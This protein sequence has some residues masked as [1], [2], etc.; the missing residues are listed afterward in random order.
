MAAAD[1]AEIYRLAVMAQGAAGQVVT[2]EDPLDR[3]EVELGGQ[4]HHCEIF[5]V[6]GPVAGGGIAVAAHEMVEHRV[7][8]IGV[9]LQVH[10]HEAGK[11]Q[12]ARIDG[13]AHAG[14]ARRHGVDAVPLEPRETLFLGQCVDGGGRAAGI[15][16]PAHQ[17]GRTGHERMILRL[18]PGDGGQHRHG[19]LAHGRD[20]EIR[21]ELR[22]Q[23]DAGID[24]VIE[25]KPAGA[26]RH[27][28][29]IDPVGD[30][31]L[32]AVE[33]DLDSAAQQRGVVARHRRDDQKLRL[34]LQLRGRLAEGDD[35]AERAL[36]DD[37]LRHA[38][39]EGGLG[40]DAGGALE[41]LAAGSDGAALRGVEE[42]IEG[43]LA[44]QPG[45]FRR[46]A[47]RCEHEMAS[48]VKRVQHASASLEQLA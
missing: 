17:H 46:Q 16:G 35:A 24:V 13:A 31:D 38:E 12:E 14:I 44:G 29:G 4:V 7:V 26:R 43:I 40:V 1:R 6:E 32:M 27:L 8:G 21:S 23:G 39:P 42:G 25:T 33:E 34:G 36:P 2:D 41:H 10:P 48:L 3:L 30:E 28:T 9:P 5:V 18:H 15:D 22:E 20:V 19:G 11:L 37:P 47:H 45:G